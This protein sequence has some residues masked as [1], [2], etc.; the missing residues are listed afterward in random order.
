MQRTGHL[1]AIASLVLLIFGLSL[2]K[3]VRTSVEMSVS[4]PGFRSTYGIPLYV[5]CFAVA[6]LSAVFA[7]VYTI[8]C[9]PFAKGASEW[10][11]S[12]SLTGVLLFAIGYG[13]LGVFG[14]S[15]FAAT[16]P[17]RVRWQ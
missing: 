10:H 15:E 12:L 5:P 14:S 1:F 7:V 11:F 17:C 9:V 8:S 3:Y 2:A 13:M 6:A 16:T 4:W